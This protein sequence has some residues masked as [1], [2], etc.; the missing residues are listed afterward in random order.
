MALQRARG[1]QPR[2]F[3]PLVPTWSRTRLHAGRMMAVQIPPTITWTKGLPDELGGLHNAYDPAD[4]TG[5]VVGD[6]TI[7]CIL[8][9][10]QVFLFNTTGRFWT[11]AEL[12]P[13][14]LK[15]YSLWCGYVQGDPSTDQ[16]GN[17]QTVLTNWMTQG[18]ELP[19]GTLH[20]ISG[21]IEIDP[22]NEIELREAIAICGAVDFGADIP[23]AYDQINPGDSWLP[24]QGPPTGGHC[25]FGSDFVPAELVMDSWGFKV[26]MP[27]PAV[28]QYV[29]E[30]YAILSTDWIAKTGR[31]P[32]GMSAA[33]IDAMMAP[34]RQS[35]AHA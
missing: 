15:Y 23:D 18:I 4:P 27:P 17:I 33:D 7:A 8:H 12:S 32:F 31:S 24:N 14:A 35:V 9:I 30:A 13:V 20:K 16:G 29:D 21:L 1:R 26:P 10:I 19:D 34:L 2:S 25:F 5:L 22:T 3:N 6:C 11:N 28:S